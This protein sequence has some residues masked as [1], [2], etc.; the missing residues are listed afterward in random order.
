M[1]AE[2][3]AEDVMRFLVHA[4]VGCRAKMGEVNARGITPGDA[5][6]VRFHPA[7]MPWPDFSRGDVYS[8]LWAL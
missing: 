2:A 1:A 3:D 6:A 5:A 8:K 7:A 4:C